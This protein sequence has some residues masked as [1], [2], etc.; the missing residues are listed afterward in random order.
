MGAKVPAPLQAVAI[1]NQMALELDINAA[2]DSVRDIVL[3]LLN[4]ERVTL[5]LVDTQRKELR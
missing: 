3:E 4:C 2:V 5:F 1:L